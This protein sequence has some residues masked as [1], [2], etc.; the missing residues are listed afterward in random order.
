MEKIRKQIFSSQ[1]ET[2]NYENYEVV[3]E[4][5]VKWVKFMLSGSLEH[6]LLVVFYLHS[7]F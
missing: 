7:G 2:K 6:N 3:W 4:K 1:L 5:T